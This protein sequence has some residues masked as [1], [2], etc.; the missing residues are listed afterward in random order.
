M[1]RQ[2]YINGERLDARGIALVDQLSCGARVPN[3]RYWLNMITGAWG[4]EGG[5]IQGVVGHCQTAEPRGEQRYIEDRIFE[6]SGI[7]IIHNPV[8]SQ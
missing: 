3:G 7:S 4:Y 1:S 8:Y 6:Q 5:P 2:I